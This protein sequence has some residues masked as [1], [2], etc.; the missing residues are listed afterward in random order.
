[1]WHRNEMFTIYSQPIFWNGKIIDVI[2][3][4]TATPWLRHQMETFS[5]ATSPLCGEFT[6]LV[7]SPHK[8]QWRGA[9]M[10]SLIYVWI[11]D[12]V[13]NR[14]AGDL[15]RQRGHYDVS[16]MTAPGLQCHPRFNDI[17][18]QNDYLFQRSQHR[19]HVTCPQIRLSIVRINLQ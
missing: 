11:N 16:V 18:Y 5:W 10:C 4:P 17:V 3:P 19:L 14:E 8:G 1:M 2:A 12:W 6:A 7:N 13:K 15:R 9:L